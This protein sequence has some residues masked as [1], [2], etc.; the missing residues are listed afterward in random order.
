[1]IGVGLIF[2]VR[3]HSGGLYGDFIPCWGILCL[4]PRSQTLPP[5]WGVGGSYS[6]SSSDSVFCICLWGRF[7]N[8]PETL[9]KR[10]RNVPETA[11]GA[12]WVNILKM[13]LKIMRLNRRADSITIHLISSMKRPTGPGESRPGRDT[14]SNAAGRGRLGVRR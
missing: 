2:P 13:Q 9:Q 6:S 11:A 14:D 5:P 12:S 1:V 3:E 8:V 4:H 10:S 7:G